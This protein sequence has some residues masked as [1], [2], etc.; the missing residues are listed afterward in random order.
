MVSAGDRIRLSLNKGPARE[1]IVTGVTGSMLRVRWESGD[2]TT[3]IPGPGTLTV[4]GRSARKTSRPAKRAPGK[5]AAGGKAANGKTAAQP[6]A[7][8][9]STGSATVP[10]KRPQRRKGRGQDQQPSG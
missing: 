9:K 8:K 6:P 1:G 2:E 5:R 4:L 7:T 10:S 3:V